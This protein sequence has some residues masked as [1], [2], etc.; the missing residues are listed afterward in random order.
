[1]YYFLFIVVVVLCTQATLVCFL[2]VSLAYT[3]KSASTNFL[4]GDNYAQ[5]SN[6]YNYDK[7]TGAMNLFFDS[8]VQ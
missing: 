5:H 3:I 8:W 1:M 2:F 4:A 7:L 6:E